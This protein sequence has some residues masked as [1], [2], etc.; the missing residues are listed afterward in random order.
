MR[1]LAIAL[2]V[3]QAGQAAPFAQES[4]EAGQ[5]YVAVS[6]DKNGALAIRR[7]DGATVAV[8]K[9]PGQTTFE[10]PRLSP[11]RKA[12]GAQAMYPNCCTSYDIPLRL[13]VY[14]NGR[15]HSF[16]GDGLSIFW[17]MFTDGGR[18]VGFGQTTVHSSCGTHYEL[19]D[20]RSERLVDSLNVP[21]E[22][23]GCPPPKSG[24]APVRLPEW[25][26]RLQ[27]AR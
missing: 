9:L 25:V 26:R 1:W 15:V 13:V 27:V 6:V 8:F 22:A 12:V 23:P 11:D 19:R 4:S 17:W 3:L 7:A 14:E 2:L 24:S 20:V 16:N 18:R 21:D 10:K 5:T